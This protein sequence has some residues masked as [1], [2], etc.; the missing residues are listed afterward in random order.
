MLFISRCNINCFQEEE[1]RLNQVSSELG[2]CILDTLGLNKV[3]FSSVFN[4][5]SQDNLDGITEIANQYN[6]SINLGDILHSETFFDKLQH[7]LN[8]SMGNGN[9]IVSHYLD[10][11]NR[12]YKTKTLDIKILKYQSFY[13]GKR[14]RSKRVDIEICTRSII[15]TINIRNKQSGIYPS[16]IMCD[17]KYHNN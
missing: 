12:L 3:A 1:I 15:F 7:L 6:T 17:F 11:T 14:G 4:Y 16:H 8:Q 10:N 5:Y 13:G 9:I 2:N